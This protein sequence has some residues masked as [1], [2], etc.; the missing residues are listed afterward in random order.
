[1][2]KSLWNRLECLATSGLQD[3]LAARLSVDVDNVATANNNTVGQHDS[4]D[5]VVLAANFQF[6]VLRHRPAV[7]PRT[8][9]SRGEL[10]AGPIIVAAGLEHCRGDGASIRLWTKERTSFS[11]APTVALIASR[12]VGELREPSAL[13]SAITWFAEMRVGKLG[14]CL[15]S[16]WDCDRSVDD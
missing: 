3:T 13:H 2:R 5:L 6:C 12:W 9:V 8:W 16:V 10:G 1:M 7:R 14:V 4:S 15:W 11:E